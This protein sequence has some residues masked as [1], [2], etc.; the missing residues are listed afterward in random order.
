MA[1][2]C[3]N[4]TTQWLTALSWCTASTAWS[5]SRKLTS[6]RRKSTNPGTKKRYKSRQVYVTGLFQSSGLL[7]WIISVLNVIQCRKKTI[8]SYESVYTYG[9]YY[10]HIHRS[11]YLTLRQNELPVCWQVLCAT[12]RENLL[13]SR[14]NISLAPVTAAWRLG[15]NTSICL[16]LHDETRLERRVTSPRLHRHNRNTH[17]NVFNQPQYWLLIQTI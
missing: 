4:T 5:P 12:C 1:R 6:W 8:E 14:S 3:R 11:K 9:T 10:I 17:L 2:S 16:Y 15:P 7:S 13:E